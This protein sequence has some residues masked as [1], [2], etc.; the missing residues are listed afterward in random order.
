MQS[1]DDGV[2]GQL[3][4]LYDSGAL[5]SA[6]TES[7]AKRLGA[8]TTRKGPIK[9]S[10]V[11]GEATVAAG[12]VKSFTLPL[13]DGRDVTISA[14]AMTEIT[15]P[16]AEY[17]TGR[18]LS[19]LKK[20]FKRT[21]PGLELPEVDKV[22]GG[23]TADILLGAEY[24]CLF[25]QADTVHALSS[26]LAVGRAKLHSFSGKQGVLWGVHKSW[27]NVAPTTNAAH[28]FREE[29]RAPLPPLLA[30]SQSFI[31]A[32]CEDYC[33]ALRADTDSECVKIEGE[34]EGEGCQWTTHTSAP[35]STCVGL[36]T[37]LRPW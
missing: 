7:A 34:R 3:L 32:S 20:D 16:I 30:E 24:S 21:N 12:G 35:R 15:A 31:Y 25:P 13:T 6:V 8:R 2:G 14:I 28:L 26:G 4:V 27:D 22:V 5:T 1:V 19:D 11:G 33:A 18:A 37:R 23:R 29:L 17:P 9:L 36:K 10:V